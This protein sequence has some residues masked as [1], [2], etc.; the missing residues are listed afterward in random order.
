MIIL[1]DEQLAALPTPRLLALYKARRV[2]LYY[3]RDGWGYSP[4]TVKL[5]IEYVGK[6]KKLLNSREH[7]NR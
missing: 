7:V 4:K 6:L 1:S 2:E 5:D 3:Y